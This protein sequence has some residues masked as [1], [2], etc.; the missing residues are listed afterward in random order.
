MT[1]NIKNS[2]SY[3]DGEIYPPLSIATGHLTLVDLDLLRFRSFVVFLMNL[4][5]LV[6][7]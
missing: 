4:S 1:S 3:D 7:Q 2:D 5:K 6:Y